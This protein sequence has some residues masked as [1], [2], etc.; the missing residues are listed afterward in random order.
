M[1]QPGSPVNGLQ[2]GVAMGRTQ[3]N[4]GTKHTE[5]NTVTQMLG[6]QQQ[7]LGLL[8]LWNHYQIVNTPII[9]MTELSGNVQYTNTMGEQLTYTVPYKTSLPKVLEDI[10]GD[11]DRVGI[12]REKFYTVLDTNRY[13]K[14]DILTYNRRIGV[15]C[16]V[17]FDEEVEP[18]SSGWKYCLRV[19]ST[20]PKAYVPRKFLQPDVEWF[21]IGHIKTEWSTENSA[22]SN[23]SDGYETLMFQTGETLQGLEHVMTGNADMIELKKIPEG[24]DKS[25]LN[26]YCNP[27]LA[28]IVYMFETMGDP[29]DPNNKDR[30]DRSKQVKGSGRWMPTII[31]M[32]YRE[33]ARMQEMHCMWN[34]GGVI[35]DGR[36][37]MARVGMGLYPQLKTGMYRQY[38]DTRQLLNILKDVVGTMFYGRSDLPMHMRRVKFEMGMGAL[39]EIQ[40]AF[41]QEYRKDNP[42]TVLA[43]HP[44]LKGLLSGDSMN[45]RYGGFRFVSYNFPEAGE[46]MI[47][48][49]PALDFE[50]TKSETT[51][52]GRYPNSSYSILVKDLTDPTFSNAIPQGQVD[53]FNNGKNIVMLKPKNYADTHTVFQ[54]G[55]YC[56]DFLM[57]YAGAGKNAHISS[58]DFFGF[59][60][61]LFW[62]GEVWLKDPSRVI[63]IE[64][65][66]PLDYD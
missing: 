24:M 5:A 22:I 47:E 23:D 31:E 16:Y 43:D 55:D 41:A 29:Y 52:Y 58:G 27:H 34:T 35:Y 54:I 2:H 8:K 7:Y 9:S 6:S 10:A 17:V 14:G 30:Y 25:L 59:K 39:I 20:D 46:V 33:Q 1:I 53:S 49:N 36:G 18:Y 37:T 4:L 40:K 13:Q 15:Q 21:K 60:I 64:R 42:F 51:F 12:G 26:Q 50:G 11:Q 66:D 62:A 48:H 28:S 61:K 56:P 38:S 32:L 65:E 45:L 19:K 3:L 63:L 57:Q 44:A